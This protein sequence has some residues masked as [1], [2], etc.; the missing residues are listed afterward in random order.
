VEVAR[1][2]VSCTFPARFQLVAAANP[3]PCGWRGSER[4]DCRCDD[5]AVFRYA[6]RMSGPLLDRID[7]HVPVPAVRWSELA[8]LPSGPESR[9]V[10]ERVERCRALQ[11][12][13][14]SGEPGGHTNASIPDR[15][16][17]TAVALTGEAR[18]LLGRAADRLGLSARSLRRA[19]RVAR[20]IADLA[21]ARSV[22][23][24]H[25]AEAIG[26]RDVWDVRSAGR[27]LGRL[28]T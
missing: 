6:A 27:G 12:R 25:M 23:P 17:E 13:R 3:C 2:R 16:I 4:R 10:R 8:A 5:G 14:L 21:E 20:T 9:D 22:G 7:L 15:D 19:M 24:D 26:Y 18:A 28:A 11:R 1:A